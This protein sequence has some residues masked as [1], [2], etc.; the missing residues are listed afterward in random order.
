[1]VNDLY[2]LDF[3][4]AAQPAIHFSGLFGSNYYVAS[5]QLIYSA[6]GRYGVQI[7]F[8]DGTNFVTNQTVIDPDNSTVNKPDTTAWDVHVNNNR[9][10]FAYGLP[11]LYVYDITNPYAP[12]FVQQLNNGSR[13]TNLIADGTRLFTVHTANRKLSVVNIANANSAVV[14]GSYDFSWG[15]TKLAKSG[16][17][18]VAMNADTIQLLDVS[19]LV[20]I[21]PHSRWLA[22]K[23]VRSDNRFTDIAVKGNFLVVGTYEGTYVYNVSNLD[24]PTVQARWLTGIYQ[25]RVFYNGTKLLVSVSDRFGGDS[26]VRPYPVIELQV[27]SVTTDVPAVSDLQLPA[28]FRLDQNYPN[29]FNPTTQIEYRIA[30]RELVT[31]KVFNMLGQEIATLVNQE[32]NPGIYRATWDGSGFSSGIYYCRMQAGSYSEIRKLVLL[33]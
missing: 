3:G 30:D 20:A 32:M 18:L 23:E 4:P 13:W 8:T 25:G 26:P 29:P 19:N 7:G 24:A 12:A 33:R 21:V 22:P 6:N 31:L 9:L 1:M 16:N 10:Y 5:P 14:E 17:T 15:V 11:G 28:A 27:Q 2:S